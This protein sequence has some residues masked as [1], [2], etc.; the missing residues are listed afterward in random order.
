MV[1]YGGGPPPNPYWQ[2]IPGQTREQRHR[3]YYNYLTGDTMTE[4]QYLRRY[5]RGL[6]YRV[7]RPNGDQQVYPA[8]SDETL[9]ETLAYQRDVAGMRREQQADRLEQY[10]YEQDITYEEARQDFYT[11]DQ[12]RYYYEYEKNVIRRQ[13]GEDSPEY[14]QFMAADGEFAQVLVNLG[15]RPPEA[16]WM[17]GMSGEQPGWPAAYFPMRG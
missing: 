7:T 12:Q 5:R 6:D 2:R 9:S 15:L 11:L 10:A 1:Y 8:V 16:D 13:Y 3:G 4:H 14:Q 17:V